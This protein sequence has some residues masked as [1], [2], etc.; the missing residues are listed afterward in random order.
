MADWTTL[1]NTA[2]G[3]GGLP[4]GTTVTALRDNPIAIAEGA[5][6]APKV[7][8]S[9]NSVNLIAT[10]TM[11]SAVQSF[12]IIDIPSHIDFIFETDPGFTVAGSTTGFIVDVSVDNGANWVQVLNEDASVGS[13]TRVNAICKCFNDGFFINAV[14]FPDGAQTSFTPGSFASGINAIRFRVGGGSTISSAIVK[15]Y[16]IAKEYE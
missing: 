5:A 1:P 2:V 6:G 7:R 11:T 14:R 16:G 9:A 10:G 12:S 8:G 15:F 13:N 4:S 3:V